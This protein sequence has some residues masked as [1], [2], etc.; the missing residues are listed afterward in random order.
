MLLFD[1]K[2]AKTKYVLCSDV[3]IIFKNNYITECIRELENNLNQVLFCTMRPLLSEKPI[4]EFDVIENFNDLVNRSVFQNVVENCY[5]FIFGTSIIF[6]LREWF[7]EIN[8]YDETYCLWGAEDEDLIKRFKM[9]KLNMKNMDDKTI[10]LHQ[11]HPKYEGLTNND[12]K[13]IEKNKEY[14][15]KTNTVLRNKTGWGEILSGS[16]E[17]VDNLKKD[18]INKLKID[19][20]KNCDYYI[21]D[22]LI[23][24]NK[25]YS[26]FI[27]LNEIRSGSNLLKTLLN[28]HKNAFCFSEIFSPYCS[29]VFNG[30]FKNTE[31]LNLIRDKYPIKFLENMVFSGYKSDINAVGIKII[32]NH[33]VEFE[34]IK[35]YLKE[36]NI[37]IIHLRRKNLL[38]AFLSLKKANKSGIWFSEGK[39]KENKS[40]DFIRLDYEDCLKFFEETSKKIKYFDDF[41]K[42]KINIFYEDL[43]KN[44]EFELK[45]IQVFLGL[46]VQKLEANLVKQETKS[47]SDSILNYYELKEKFK[48]SKWEVFF[49]D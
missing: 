44:R 41:Y 42:N 38:K 48:G 39:L 11:W 49:E 16:G 36:N 28:S 22:E 23:G 12:K 30:A 5:K 27:I 40:I 31:K 15:F 17:F 47:I 10:H 3:D 9:I 46:E 13:Q 32:Y 33:F 45:K 24:K 14:F 26:K 4:Q 35:N 6:V 8:G 43:I 21:S 29:N 19:F 1:I 2:K 7:Y 25:D 18:E 20:P 34:L 37:K